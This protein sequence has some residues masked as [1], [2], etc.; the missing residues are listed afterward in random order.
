MFKKLMD[1]LK[2]MASGHSAFDPSFFDDSVAMQTEWG[3]AKGGGANFGTHK[4]VTVNPSR[5]EFK[6]S[7]GAKLFYLLFL[8]VGL[9]VLIGFSVKGISS[10]TLG[11]NADTVLP[12]VFGSIFALAGGGMFYVGTAP[13]VFDKQ[14]GWFWKGR[15]APDRVFDKSAIKHLAE[16]GQIHALQLISEHCSGDKSSY[17]SYEINIVLEDGRRINDVDHGNEKRIRADADT[18]SEFLG[19]PLWDGI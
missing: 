9:G 16:I 15:K 8:F 6:A 11:L 7:I 10:G 2:S 12:L 13:I 14:K 1:K 5:L 17:Y 18:L 3:P 19:I 4:L